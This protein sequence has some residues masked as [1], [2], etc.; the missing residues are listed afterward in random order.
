[1]AIFQFTMFVCQRVVRNCIGR[2]QSPEGN[3]TPQTP[4]GAPARPFTLRTFMADV[5]GIGCARGVE[6]A[7]PSRGWYNILRAVLARNKLHKWL[8]LALNAC[9]ILFL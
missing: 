4:M 2:V 9:N 1:M 7:S 5:H 3:P 6:A 8:K